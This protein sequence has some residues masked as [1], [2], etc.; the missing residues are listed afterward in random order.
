MKTKVNIKTEVHG[1]SAMYQL[2]DDLF[3]LCHPEGKPTYD[4]ELAAEDTLETIA[5]DENVDL[6]MLLEHPGFLGFMSGWCMGQ[7]CTQVMIIKA[8]IEE[9]MK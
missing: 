4:E 5:Y 6:D 7:K 1:E 3:I 2:G 9:V 8:K